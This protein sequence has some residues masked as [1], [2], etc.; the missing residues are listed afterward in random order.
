MKKKKLMILGAGATQVPLVRVSKELG[1]HTVVA[2]IDGNYPAFD[3]CDEI[4]LVDISEPSAVLEKAIEFRIDGITTC[5][6]DTGIHAVGYVAERLGLCNIS[7]SAAEMCYNKLLMKRAFLDNGVPTADFRMVTDTH[8]LYSA[9]DEIGFPL[10]IKA[11]DLQG[12]RGIYIC[13]SVDEAVNGYNN[14]MPVTKKDFC[15]VEKYLEGYEFGAQAFIYNHDILFVLPHGD[16][17]YMSHTA[18]PIG[19]YAPFDGD[20]QLKE[21]SDTVVRAAID[22]IGLDN[23]AVNVDL[24]VEDNTVYVIELTG[25]V[26]ATC[27]PELVSIYYGIDYYKMI[28]MAA[29]GENPAQVFEKRNETYTANASRMLLSEKSGRIADI[30]L[31]IPEDDRIYEVSMIVE[32]GSEI[33][34]FENAKDRI[35]Q[36]IVKGKTYDDCEKLIQRIQNGITIILDQDIE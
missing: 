6:L 34:K 17:T 31:D 32:K 7:N 27:L 16:N 28:A 25:R 21:Q 3:V 12:S 15:I 23:C 13:R 19:H 26:G 33:N 9:M 18:V 22:A 8:E 20:N 29:M 2:S 1:Y 24:I 11:V 36:V 30:M 14:V 5:C 35:G 4:A 10:I